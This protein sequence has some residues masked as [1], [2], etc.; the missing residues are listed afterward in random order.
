MKTALIT[1]A[2]RGI[3]L[4]TTKALLQAGWR[5]AMLDRD[6]DVL[7]TEAAKLDDV[8]VVVADVSDPDQVTRA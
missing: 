2:A 4:A 6:E 7:R 5:V 3:G 8:L 1:G